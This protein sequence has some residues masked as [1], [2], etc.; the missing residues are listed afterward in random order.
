MFVTFFAEAQTNP[1]AFVRKVYD[2]L[3][4]ASNYLIKLNKGKYS[5]VLNKNLIIELY[6]K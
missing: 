4:H 6:L 2:D 3:Y 1:P 5:I